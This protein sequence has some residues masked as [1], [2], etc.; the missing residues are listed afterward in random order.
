V[1]C[2]GGGE[3]L[4]RRDFVPSE[5]A[6]ILRGVLIMLSWAEELQGFMGAHAASCRI[7]M[8]W[9]L[10]VR[11]R[12]S[13]WGADTPSSAYFSSGS[14]QPLGPTVCRGSLLVVLDADS[15]VKGR[16]LFATCLRLRAATTSITA[17]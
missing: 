6:L 16:L 14:R 17:F 15:G 11:P 8:P 12:H 3:A 2:L 7:E 9:T 4:A 1:V 13:A 10:G 5:G